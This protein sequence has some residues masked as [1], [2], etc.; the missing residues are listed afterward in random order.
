[1]NVSSPGRLG[2]RLL[3][4][5][6]ATERMLVQDDRRGEASGSSSPEQLFTA[7]SWHSTPSRRPLLAP[8]AAAAPP[9]RTLQE[10]SADLLMLFRIFVPLL[11]NS[12]RRLS[13]LVPRPFVRLARFLAFR[14]AASLHKRN[15]LGTNIVYDTL[16]VFWKT[17]V[18]LFFREIESRSAWRIPKEGDGA[19][20][21]VCGPHSNQV[22]RV[23]VSGRER[24]S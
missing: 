6:I 16:V 7:P 3:P 8:E 2:L 15:L 22:R 11:P 5:P 24:A 20:I 23:R 13:V 17:V 21:F 9:R 12:L 4:H 18:T 19:V 1:M 14:V 10:T